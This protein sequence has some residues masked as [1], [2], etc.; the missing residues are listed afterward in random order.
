MRSMAMFLLTIDPIFIP[1]RFGILD[2]EFKV[3]CQ[4]TLVS[5]S[6]KPES[7]FDQTGRFLGPGSAER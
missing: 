4:L 3:F 2:F 7:V 1:H 6:A 5:D